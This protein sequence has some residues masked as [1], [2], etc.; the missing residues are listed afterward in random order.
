[1]AAGV[2]I[3]ASLASVQRTGGELVL[4]SLQAAG[5]DTV[6]GIISVHNIPI[7]DAMA[8]EGGVRL[9]PARTEHGAAAMADGFARATGRLA[10]VVTSTGVGAGNAAGSL[11]EAYSASSPV[12]H[13]TGQVEAAFV[14][15]DKG[16]LHGVNDQLGMLERVG[17]AAYRAQRTEE[18]PAMMWAAMSLARSGRPGPVSVEIPIDQQYRAID[19]Y[20]DESIPPPTPVQPDPSDIDRAAGLIGG[21]R[22]P[23]IWAGGGV[24]SADASAELTTLAQRI[25]AGVIT[26]AA[27]RGAMSEDHAQCIGFFPVDVRVGELLE[28]SDLLL[29]VGTRFRGNE[30]RNWELGLPVPRIQIDVEPS[31]LGRNY[32]IDV[33]IVGDARL[34]LAALCAAVPSARD[35][36]WL[37]TI[38]ETR[39]DARTRARDTLGP[40]ARI[41]DD[42]RNTLPRDAI[43]VRDVTIPATTWGARLL[44]TYVPR[45]VLYSATYAIGMGFG[46]AI[47]AAIGQ[48]NRDVVLLAGDGGFITAL[49]ELATTA[50]EKARVRIILF[51]DGGYGILRNLQDNHFDGRRFGVDLVTPDFPRLAESFGIWS[52]Q[53]RSSVEFG[54]VLK[55]ALVQDGPAL[56]EVDMAAI[57]PMAAP[58]TGSARLVPG[59]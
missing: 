24:I 32:P 26:T 15:G 30:T 37:T 50:Q 9:V 44:E 27:G 39:L 35:A 8:R 22:R 41:L 47:G 23:L 21:A 14:D 33:G 18:I 56:I 36:D 46:L 4:D 34:A 38:A 6:F 49:G 51:N 19:A 54:P 10:A 11:L 28:K 57:G 25:G 48:P 13:V 17:K 20:T 7:F 43:V 59:R 58:F 52:G 5:V 31:L 40:Y 3:A 42:L 16:F 2:F 12:I 55:E 29:A 53:V 45:T 1:M